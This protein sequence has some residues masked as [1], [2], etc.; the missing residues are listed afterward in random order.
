MALDIYHVH[1][2]EHDRRTNQMVMVGKKPYKRFVSGSELP[3]NVQ[4]RES[5]TSARASR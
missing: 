4:R 1:A 3:I 5:S 2:M